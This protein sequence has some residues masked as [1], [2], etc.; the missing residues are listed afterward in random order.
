MLKLVT[1]L[2]DEIRRLARKEVRAQTMTTK[3]AAAAH[4]REIARLKR[5]VAGYGKKLDRLAV[6]LNHQGEKP[7]AGADEID[8]SNR[9]SAR[10]V[11]AQRR[12]LNLSAADYGRLIGVTGQ[13]IYQWE[14]GKSRPRRSQFAELVGVRGLGR[15]GALT[16]LNELNEK[17]AAA[18]EGSKRRKR[19]AK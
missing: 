2:K 3:R 14:Q 10:S 18:A 7:S 15:R 8:S 1:A 11:R 13:T 5:M 4:R 9:F 12:R 17:R 19:R 16:R 6:Q